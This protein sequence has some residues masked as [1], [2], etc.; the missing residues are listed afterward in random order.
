MGTIVAQSI[1]DKAAQKLLDDGN[2]RWTEAELLSDLNDGQREIV[3]L[4]P[5]AGAVTEVVQLVA[6]TR[7]TIPPGGVELLHVVRNMGLDG[8]TPGRAITPL[9]METLDRYEPDWHAA[10]AAI[11]AKHYLFDARDPKSFYVT[12][13]QP[14]APGQVEI[15]YAK[16]PADVL[17]GESIAVDDI[18]APAL[19]SYVM[20]RAHSKET[21]GADQTKAAAY[22]SMFREA[23]GLKSAAE[24]RTRA[25]AP[26]AQRTDQ[27][28]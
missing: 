25:R 17:I 11:A 18:Y 28:A 6:G 10:S 5:S 21:P 16:A 13:P 22:Y 9:S 20:A 3:L 8:S 19:L 24:D 14:G 4:K 15:V 26:A 12:P 2:V 23:L 27:A 1:V 7:Q